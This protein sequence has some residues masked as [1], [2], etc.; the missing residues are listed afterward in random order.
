LAT[1]DDL[2]RAGEWAR[3]ATTM[4]PNNQQAWYVL[5]TAMRFGP[6]SNTREANEAFRHCIALPGRFTSECR[7]G[8]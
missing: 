8:G 6:H 4:D 5:G 7:S 2:G 1:R 3:R